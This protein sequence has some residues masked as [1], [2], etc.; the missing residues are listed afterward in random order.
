MPAAS[1]IAIVALVGRPNVGKSRLFNRFT[2]HRRALVENTPGI[3]RDRIAEEIDVL[4]RRVLLVD[5]AGL[6]PDP[7]SALHS[8][9]Q[10]QARSAVEQADAILFVV[11]G[12]AGLL[13]EDEAI[14]KTLRRSNKPIA[15]AVNKLDTHA[16]ADRLAGFYS[17]GMEPTRAVSAE[18]GLGAFDL[19]E[20]LVGAM[21][22]DAAPDEISQEEGIR[23][24]FVGRPNVGKSTLVNRLLGEERV[25]V[26][27]EP[28]TTRDSVD[29]ALE[30]DD[31]RYVLVDTAGLRRPGRRDRIAERGSALM[32]VRSL[33][34][35][36]VAFLVVD[37]AD[38]FSD[39][40][41]RIASLIEDRGCAVGILANKWDAVAK[42]R[43]EVVKEEIR[44]GLRFLSHSP[45]LS[46]SA[47]RGMR[48]GRILPLA[49]DL[50]T[51]GTTRIPTS[52]LNRWLQAAVAKHEPSM[53]R[54]GYSR[55]PIKFF[56]ATQ[57]GV[58]PPSFVLFCTEPQA[59]KTSYR[60]FL[61]NRLRE[62]FGF[63]GTP[64]RLVLRAR[65]S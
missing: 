49:Q 64:V 58:R 62:T 48:V 34:R 40:D 50:Y 29:V 65:K 63:E 13:P 20:E 26:S 44:H 33:E 16:H 23:I 30:R 38:G 43:R 11:D 2:G 7:D 56:Y 17:L 1:R 60:R 19:L 39:Q 27:D 25:V 10:S 36:Q 18:H 52:E 5:T 14:A 6:D 41:A 57:T 28:G 8:A 12:R 24:A 53:A 61:E 47:T 4:G 42:D 9:I 32:T 3:T 46:I 37:A 54:R 59:I 21:D 35:A 31:Q 22:P 45:L 15:V 55:R 51:V